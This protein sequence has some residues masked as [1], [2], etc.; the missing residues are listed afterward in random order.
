MRI[1]MTL[2]TLDDVSPNRATVTAVRA[3]VAADVTPCRDTGRMPRLP[4]HYALVTDAA[5]I[6]EVSE[7]VWIADGATRSRGERVITGRGCSEGK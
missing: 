5:L 3:V 6:P 1:D 4:L 7:R 2:V